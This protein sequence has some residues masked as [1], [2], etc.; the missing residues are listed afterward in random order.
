MG[1]QE[2]LP[3]SPLRVPR[4]VFL[5]PSFV[6]AYTLQKPTRRRGEREKKEKEAEQINKKKW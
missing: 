3:V 6:C 1:E 5:C 2:T 4:P